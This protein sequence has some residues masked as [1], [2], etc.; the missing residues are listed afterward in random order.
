MTEEIREG[1]VGLSDDALKFVT[2]IVAHKDI[3]EEDRP[4]ESIVEA[5][6]FAFALGFAR[7]Q[8]KKAASKKSNIFYK[9]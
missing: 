7:N 2:T 8:R 6:R 1:S 3:Y 9:I 5:F 4:F